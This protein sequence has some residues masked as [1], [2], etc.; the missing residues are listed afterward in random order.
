VL[1]VLTVQCAL[2]GAFLVPLR[3]YGV[4]APVSVPF[5][6][7]NAPLVYAGRRVARSRWGGPPP[8]LLWLGL[9]LQ[10]GTPTSGGDI[11]IEA[12]PTGYA[13][14][15]IGTFAAVVG[16][17][18]P[19]RPVGAV[20]VRAGAAQRARR[21]APGG[22]LERQEAVVEPEWTGGQVVVGERDYRGLIAE[23]EAPAA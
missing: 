7:A 19:H 17:A 3:L 8:A 9:V 12:T 14:L 11:A 21:P 4:V 20:L 22:V 13:F 1:V 15:L 5:A 23:L 2:W 18:M 16:I 6:V 10:L